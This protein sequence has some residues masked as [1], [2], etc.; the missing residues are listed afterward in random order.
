MP[1]SPRRVP[2]AVRQSADLEHCHPSG[3]PL[4]Q[5]CTAGCPRQWC[6]CFQH[7]D[8][9]VP[10]F[11][12][13]TC[14]S[15]RTPR[16]RRQHALLCTV[17][18]GSALTVSGLTPWDT[19]SEGWKEGEGNSSL[20]ASGKKWSFPLGCWRLRKCLRRE[21]SSEA[22]PRDQPDLNN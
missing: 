2:A 19:E 16:P 14:R 11:H 21:G 15:A 6:R 13:T 5:R 3:G 8:F 9:C 1:R 10:G 12:T 22:P 4:G 18:G 17:Q 7:G 20:L